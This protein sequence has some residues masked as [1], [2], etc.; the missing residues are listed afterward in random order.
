MLNQDTPIS[1]ETTVTSTETMQQPEVQAAPVSQPSLLD[2]LADDLKT[3]KSLGNF[4]D[5]NE[6]A[7]SYLNAQS[8]IGKRISDMSGDDLK[9]LDAIRGVPEAPEKYVLPEELPNEVTD[10]YKQ[11]AAQAKLTQEQAKTVLD[12]YIMLERKAQETMAAQQQQF[13]ETSVET[14]KKEFG[15]AFDQKLEIAKRAVSTFGGDELKQALNE[16]GLG[17][18]PAFVK[19]FAK[20][21]QQLLED[22][23]VEADKATTF[24]VSPAEADAMIQNKMLDPDFRQAYI[25]GHHPGHSAA[26]AEMAR[27]YELRG[28]AR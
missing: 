28:G 9:A 20:I 3:A 21:G 14:L 27:L 7:K 1:V 6:L 11:I 26:V 15:L 22:T 18:H 12:S 25:S 2:S 8:L 16:T 13:K 19:V 4:K 24:G 10:A 17:D 23:T 5:V